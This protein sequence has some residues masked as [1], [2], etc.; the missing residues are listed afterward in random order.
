MAVPAA[1]GYVSFDHVTFRYP[2]A[3]EAA[4][5]DISFT[6]EPGKVTAIIG[7]TGAG[8]STLL[9]LLL[10][11]HD[12]TEGAV[13][14][15]GVDVRQ[16]TQH[17]LRAK[18]AYVPQRSVLF[19][20]TIADNVRYGDLEASDD[21]V[22]HA[23]ATAQA[24]EFIEHLPGGLQSELR[25]GGVNLSGGQRQRVA[26]ARALVRKAEVYI[27]DDSFS[28]LDYRTDALLRAA[29]RQ[30]FASSTMLIVA[31]RVSTVQDAD[32]IL[33]LEDGRLVGVGTHSELLQTCP[34]YAEIVSSQGL[35]GAV[36]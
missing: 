34:T 15:D 5:S 17:A 23:L 19:T 35:P 7:G 26:I 29:L 32:R 20:G 11:F 30:N 3:Q 22:A 24:T 36:A 16:Q 4:L 2:G 13:R 33:V 18:I 31:Q 8:K 1:G 10:R 28:A 25:Q 14:L 6:A 27:F 9:Q 12:C 21:A